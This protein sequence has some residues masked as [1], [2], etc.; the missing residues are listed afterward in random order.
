MLSWWE[1]LGANFVLVVDVQKPRDDRGSAM[2]RRG[3]PLITLM[4]ERGDE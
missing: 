2:R 3:L 1:G 4:S